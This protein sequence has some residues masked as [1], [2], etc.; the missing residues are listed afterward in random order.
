VNYY[1]F[2]FSLNFKYPICNV[3]GEGKDEGGIKEK[4]K[5]E[6]EEPPILFLDK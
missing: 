4:R 2:F 6:R 5:G 1:L 3:F